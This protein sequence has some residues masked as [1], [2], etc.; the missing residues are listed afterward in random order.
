M[1]YTF[2]DTET[3]GL[4]ANCDILSFSYMWADE[5]L[6]IKKAETLYF[7]KEGVTH[8]TQEAYEINHLSKE[9][10]RKYADDYDKNLQKMYLFLN[11]AS[12]VGYNSGWVGGDG[13][14]HGFDYARCKAFLT[15]NGYPEPRPT[16]FI[17]VM[18]MVERIM[19]RKL[20][21]VTAFA[22]MGLSEDIAHAIN[23]VYFSGE[24][25]SAHESSF[26]TIM[27]AMLFQKL[28]S[29][30]QVS[31]S[32]AGAVWSA[33][34]E[35]VQQDTVWMLFFDDTELKALSLIMVDDEEVINVYTMSELMSKDM[36][37]FDYLMQ[38]PSRCM[39]SDQELLDTVLGNNKAEG[40]FIDV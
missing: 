19:G 36:K 1:L 37:V 7:W 23:S 18:K 39:C 12:L 13:V 9:F 31:A 10:L 34:S 32:S 38:D 29:D 5:N 40:G 28:W 4:E 27:T 21:L 24:D 35:K 8:W 15:R 17:D 2:F 11:F 14:I 16:E 26:D 33:D 3:S 6:D 30:G 22:K 20:K 25:G